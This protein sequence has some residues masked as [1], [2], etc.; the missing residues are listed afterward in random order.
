MLN[1]ELS[2]KPMLNCPIL[3][4]EFRIQEAT[5]ELKTQNSKFKKTQNSKLKMRVA[6]NSKLKIQKTQNSNYGNQS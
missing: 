2:A 5:T 4:W 6:H 3:N 1:V